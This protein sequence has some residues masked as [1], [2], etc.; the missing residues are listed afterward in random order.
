[1]S[2]TGCTRSRL[3]IGHFPRGESCPE[4]RGFSVEKIDDT[5]RTPDLFAE[6][7]V[8]QD[9]DEAAVTGDYL[10]KIFLEAVG[11]DG[12]EPDPND[13]NFWEKHD[14]IHHHGHFDPETQT[15]TLR[16]E[17]EAAEEEKDAG[18]DIGSEQP[19][20]AGLESPEK[21]GAEESGEDLDWEKIDAEY[22]DA[23]ER[24]DIEKCTEMVRQAAAKAMPDTKIVDRD[25]LPL[26]V[27]HGTGGGDFNIFDT[28][29]GGLTSGE[30]GSGAFFTIKKGIAAAYARRDGQNGKVKAVFLN[31]KKPF[32]LDAK[33][34]YYSDLPFPELEKKPK[35]DVK[36]SDILLGT[37]TGSKDDTRYG[38]RCEELHFNTEEEAQDFRRKLEGAKSRDFG[39]LDNSAMIKAM[40]QDTVRE[41]LKETG[42][43]DTEI[44]R[45]L[46]QIKEGIYYGYDNIKDI[47]STWLLTTEEGKK[48][49]E[50]LPERESK[51]S[52]SAV[53]LIEGEREG[54][55]TD[56]VAR[57]VREKGENDGVIILDVID[58]PGELGEDIDD[59]NEINSTTSL[60]HDSAREMLSYMST[61]VVAF[62]SNQIKS[63]DPITY[64]D[65]GTVVPLSKRF[66][67]GNPDIRFSKE[68]GEAGSLWDAKTRAEAEAAAGIFKQCLYGTEIVFSDEAF[69]GG[70]GET[71]RASI[72]SPEMDAAYMDAVKRGDMEACAEIVKE[73]ATKS[74]YTEEAWHFGELGL[75]NNR[76]YNIPRGV[77]HYG[78]REAALDRLRN[79][80]DSGAY[81]WAG[82]NLAEK[83]GKWYWQFKSEFYDNE[84]D[85]TKDMTSGGP[86]DT[87]EQAEDAMAKDYGGRLSKVYLN[88][89][90]MRTVEKDDP[91]MS[92]DEPILRYR[93]SQEDPGSY[94]FKVSDPSRVKSADPVVYDDDGN[95][96]PLSRRFDQSSDDIRYAK[97]GSGYSLGAPYQGSKGRIAS[98]IIDLL[99]EGSRFVD[100]FSG[101]GAMTHAAML[102]GKFDSYRMNDVSP[103]GQDLFLQGIRGE[104]NDY[105]RAGMTKESFEGIKGT[106]EGIIW[107]FNNK[108]NEFAGGEEGLKHARR[109]IERMKRLGE[110]SD[111]ADKVNASNLDY[112]QVEIRPGDVLY[113]DIPYEGTNRRGYG[114]GSFDK[115]AFIKWAEGLEQ[116]VFVSEHQMPDGWTEIGSWN[117]SGIRGRN[118][119]EKLFVQDRFA[120]RFLNGREQRREEPKMGIGGI[121]TG[122]GADYANRSRQGGVDD[123]PSLKHI[124]T[125]EG[126]QVYGWGLYGS[127]VRG[128]AEGYANPELDETHEGILINNVISALV[129][130]GVDERKAET[131]ADALHENYSVPGRLLRSLKTEHGASSPE[132]QEFKKYEPI[133]R[134]VYQEDG[135]PFDIGSTVYE[136]TWFTNRPAGD[137]SHLLMWYEPTSEMNLY[138]INEQLKNEGIDAMF[139]NKAGGYEL[140]G[141]DVKKIGGGGNDYLLKAEQAPSGSDVYAKLAARI[142][143]SE[144]ETSR[145]LDRAGI[146]GIKYPVD[147]YGVKTT[148][149]GNEAGWNYVAF[150]DKNI[151][152]DHKWVD[153]EQRYF[154][155]DKGKVVGTYDRKTGKITLYPGAK[156]K[157]VVHEFSHGLWQFAEQEAAAGRSTLMTKFKGIANSAP[158]AVKDAVLANYGT[159][160]P[161]VYLEEC[162][163][164][165]MARQSDSAFAKAIQTPE[166][167]PWYR[168]AWGVIKN[169]WNRFAASKKLANVDVS[170]MDRMD[171]AQSAKFILRQLAKG[172]HFGTVQHVGRGGTRKSILGKKPYQA[173][174]TPDLFAEFGVTGDEAIDTTPDLFAEFGIVEQKSSSNKQ[175]SLPDLF[176][177]FGITQGNQKDEDMRNALLEMVIRVLE[178][179]P[180]DARPNLFSKKWAWKKSAIAGDEMDDLFL[181]AVGMDG[182]E[183][184]PNDPNFWEKH[185]KIHHGGNFDPETQTCTLREEAE[186]AEKEKD[187]GDDIGNDEPDVSGL[188]SPFQRGAEAATQTEANQSDTPV[189][190][191]A[192]PAAKLPKRI[193][194]LSGKREKQYRELMAKKHPELDADMVLTEIGKIEDKKLQEDAFKWVLKGAVR[195][196]EDMYK[197]E[198]ARELATKAQRDPFSWNTPQACINELLG[199]GHKLSLK[200]ITVEELKKDPHFSDYQ[201]LPEGVETF[202][203]EDSREGQRRMREVI[204]THWGKDANPWCLLARQEENTER[205][206]EFND[207]WDSLSAEERNRYGKTDK[208]TEENK[209]LYHNWAIEAQDNAREY[210]NTSVAKKEDIPVFGL[211][212]AWRFWNRYNALPKRV[213]FK[214]GKLLAFMATE[215]MSDDAAFDDAAYSSGSRLAE[216]YPDEFGEYEKWTETEEGQEE[217]ANFYEWLKHEY[218]ELTTDDALRDNVPEQWWDRDDEPHRGIPLGAIGIK[219]DPLNR[220][221]Q[222]E[223]SSSTGKVRYIGDATSK[224]NGVTTTWYG[225][226]DKKRSEEYP[227]GSRKVWHPNGQLRLEEKSDGSLEAFHEDGRPLEKRGADGSKKVWH[228]NGQLHTERD[229]EG[230]QKTYDENGRLRLEEMD[231]PDATFKL[232]KYDADGRLTREVLRDGTDRRYVNGHL[233]I[234]FRLNGT[235]AHYGP[236]GLIQWERLPDG[237]FREFDSETGKLAIEY[238][239]DRSWKRYSPDGK[240]IEE[241]TEES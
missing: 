89:D 36:I 184:D 94:S 181:E 138:R 169:T 87:K 4:E 144:E 113:A 119:E 153:G 13:P 157:D 188:E 33:G 107:S 206:L 217:G 16:E 186:N 227:D 55:S 26:I 28:E 240:V 159:D 161:N 79:R 47:F 109:N 42:Q 111:K 132:V 228:P 192:Q 74:G 185:D 212:S 179:E 125:G 202:E 34:D 41:K 80:A 180:D 178:E 83:D 106:S 65:D 222:A 105:N 103:K 7:G 149:D 58:I 121:F 194:G 200:P 90:G 85:A 174:K 230:N 193:E 29:V 141:S 154:K 38:L 139:T 43:S 128:V 84:E 215:P 17:A 130:A 126:A 66:Q 10:S 93:N 82:Y 70:E 91:Q 168:R 49:Y 134:K 60:Y 56:D 199:K 27:Y 226:S 219:N 131:F 67:E 14:K 68:E 147:S 236:N 127:N 225:S 44:S 52:M 164:H 220:R 57:Y 92:V 2:L 133:L 18:D 88:V 155:N 48:Y 203:V 53:R 32:T 190:A 72:I 51:V 150:S 136:Q 30:Q 9:A 231:T 166:G 224:K 5:D 148:K 102:S 112:R 137:E 117:V 163:T 210:F 221:I 195:L 123:G 172:M 183:P 50:S 152:V 78:T 237:T 223:Q 63:A 177:E 204:D 207:W 8:V 218:P 97:T 86:Y 146:D 96:I 239:A 40:G 171:A 101:G 209:D 21:R 182:R 238:L 24:G 129:E 196:P 118:P 69:R 23:V 145:F 241:G 175:E 122:S 99:P 120:N 170:K 1:M 71:T 25:G 162:F 11:M 15:C 31:I 235:S 81:E 59:K 110:L 229:T 173:D 114:S 205:N 176:A 73:A 189:S 191:N 135:T 211:D 62:N 156:P 165:E 233:D 198:Q 201:K 151:R 37:F 61:D 77:T 116:P 115:E 95:V 142:F 19:N 124:G 187:D 45:E 6:F 140:V 232:K 39:V 46:Q 214:D 35:T 216:M 167:R 12:R 3:N 76:E 104:W 143:G 108:G 197:V 20:V 64:Y 75:E 100:L 160:D 213:A 54:V 98:Q 208:F 234:E 158:K 22:M